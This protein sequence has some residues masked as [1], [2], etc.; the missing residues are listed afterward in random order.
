[1]ELLKCLFHFYTYPESQFFHVEQT[2]AQFANLGHA[3]L[4][5]QLE[6]DVR[7]QLDVEF[8]EV[9]DQALVGGVGLADD[10]IVVAALP[11]HFNDV[12][13]HTLEREVNISGVRRHLLHQDGM[14]ELGTLVQDVV[15]GFA[16][17]REAEYVR[18]GLNDEFVPDLVKQVVNADT[19]RR[20]EGQLQVLFIVDVKAVPVVALVDE[21]DFS[22]G[23]QLTSQV[24]VGEELPDFEFGKDIR[25][26]QQVL[27]VAIG[28]K[29]VV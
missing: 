2:G 21:Q 23:F 9:C 14:P 22:A 1:M 27:L 3:V 28:V 7:E 8:V 13:L 17:N 16:P 25:H 24:L 19:R 10:L 15:H 26:K 6:F 20:P 12:S 5:V 29:R 11:K 18:H 4:S